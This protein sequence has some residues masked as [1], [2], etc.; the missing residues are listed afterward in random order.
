MSIVLDAGALIAFERGDRT[1]QAYLDLAADT[2]DPVRTSAAVVAQVWR[3]GAR[4]ALLSRLLQG[5]EE[6]ALTPQ[7][8]RAIGE[9]LRLART[10]DVCDASLIE[11]ADSGDEIL[12]SDPDDLEQVAAVSGK[13]LTITAV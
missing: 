12:T 5:L 4:Q 7:R 2:G 9:L 10:S 13:I 11:L 3:G 8:G 1:I 6:I